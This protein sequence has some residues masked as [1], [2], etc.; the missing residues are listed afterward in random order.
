M[1]QVWWTI[2]RQCDLF[3]LC[4]ADVTEQRRI[5]FGRDGDQFDDREGNTAFECINAIRALGDE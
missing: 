3:N 1:P 4:V 2:K 5:T